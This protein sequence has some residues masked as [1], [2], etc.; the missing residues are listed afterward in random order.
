MDQKLLI[1][2]EKYWDEKLQIH[3]CG[4]DDSAE[5]ANH[6]PYEPTPYT[7]LQR[8]A[9]EGGIGKDQHVIDYG[10][11]KGRAAFFLNQCWTFFLFRFR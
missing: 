10:S 9:E 8:L 2:S 6:F 1:D 4:R 11:G 5:D 7:V 3:T